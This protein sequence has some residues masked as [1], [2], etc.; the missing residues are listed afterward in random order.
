LF[1]LVL[2]YEP[3]ND[4]KVYYNRKN[5]LSQIKNFHFSRNFPEINYSISTKLVSWMQ[6]SFSL[7]G[8]KFCVHSKNWKG[9]SFTSMQSLIKNT[10]EGT[11]TSKIR[12]AVAAAWTKSDTTG[13]IHATSIR[14]IGLRIT[15]VAGG[16]E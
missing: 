5:H 1:Y 15:P 3:S 10:P 12:L 8:M 2:F 7:I 9:I 4:H 14:S 13:E 11:D 6:F 16:G